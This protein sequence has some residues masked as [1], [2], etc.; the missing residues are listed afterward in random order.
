M[1]QKV[2]T[3]R[4]RV[5]YI[6]FYYARRNYINSLASAFLKRNLLSEE[7]ECLIEYFTRDEKWKRNNTS[8]YL[9]CQLLEGVFHV[10][11]LRCRSDMAHGP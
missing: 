6:S 11:R 5:K 9:T 2:H 1:K 8:D 7:K 4:H 3:L 10:L